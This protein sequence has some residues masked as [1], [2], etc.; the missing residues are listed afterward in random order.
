MK[1]DT[2]ERRVKASVGFKERPETLSSHWTPDGCLDR[3]HT[4][5]EHSW[6]CESQQGSVISH[7]WF[8]SF[9]CFLHVQLC[10]YINRVFNTYSTWS[11]VK[12]TR[13]KFCSGCL[14]FLNQTFS[15]VFTWFLVK[16]GFKYGNECST[17][18]ISDR[19]RKD[20]SIRSR[21][22]SP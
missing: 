4:I 8:H 15:V 22:V 2:E 19:G 14:T 7:S 1:H 10:T 9:G 17:L 3:E 12:S 5:K 16:K 18:H 6:R 21:V 11:M 13:I 20:D